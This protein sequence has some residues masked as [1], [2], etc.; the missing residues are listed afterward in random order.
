MVLGSIVFSELGK[1]QK[2]NKIM[3]K[4]IMI[5]LRKEI[6]GRKGIILINCALLVEAHMLSICNNNIILINVDKDTQ[7]KRL[8]DRG[9]TEEQIQ[10]R[11]NLALVHGEETMDEEV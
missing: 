11:R 8:L 3:T 4:P 9:L 2:L 5:R 7:K 6:S 1:L 10:T